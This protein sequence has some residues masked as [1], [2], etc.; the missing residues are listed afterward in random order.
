M[1]PNGHR[2]GEIIEGLPASL[3]LLLG[4]YKS[5]IPVQII[6][7]WWAERLEGPY[8]GDEVLTAET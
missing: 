5:C 7:L 2:G 3:V 6:K 8:A 1:A 4:I